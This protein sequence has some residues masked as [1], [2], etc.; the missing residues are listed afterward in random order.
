MSEAMSLFSKDTKIIIEY[1]LSNNEKHEESFTG[2]L[3][4]AMDHALNKY[5]AATASFYTE[6][7]KWLKQEEVEL[8]YG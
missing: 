7:R 3:R 6:D 2:S 1:Q 8:Y 4:K 5:P